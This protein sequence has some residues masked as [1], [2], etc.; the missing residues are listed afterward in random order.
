MSKKFSDLVTKLMD[1]TE[2][3][4]ADEVNIA[5]CQ[6]E[7]EIIGYLIG[8]KL[9]K[10]D[11][12]YVPEEIDNYHTLPLRSLNRVATQACISLKQGESGQ[13]SSQSLETETARD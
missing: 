4:I 7:A 3:Q 8:R 12:D 10:N 9:V 2:K 5:R 13:K 11:P 6:A 1:A